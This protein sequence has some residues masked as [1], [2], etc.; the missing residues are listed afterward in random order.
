MRY[1]RTPIA[2]ALPVASANL[3]EYARVNDAD[4]KAELERLARA[5]AAEIEAYADLALLSQTITATTDLW[6]GQII[7]LPVGPV[8][9]GASITVA[10]VELD[11][12]LTNIADGWWLEAGRFPRLHF[13]DG[14]PGAP[15]RITYCAGHG[16]TADVVPHDLRIAIIDEAT[17][18]FDM[19]ADD[20]QARGLSPAAL[21][22][23]ARHRRVRA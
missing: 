7:A 16:S 19:R 22:I 13:T 23:L 17:R 5:A 12:T 3:A 6:P 20:K 18:T 21:R 1:E 4:S 14:I 8:L 11:G 2:T 15:L 9:P 10:V